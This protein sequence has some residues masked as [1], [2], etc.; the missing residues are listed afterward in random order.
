MTAHI[1]RLPGLEVYDLIFA[2]HL[3]M[4]PS[5]DQDTIHRTMAN[6]AQ[7]WVGMDDGAVVA[8]WG[9]I[10]PTF[11]SDRA[12]LW[13][14]TTD[15]LTSHVFQL[16]RHSQRAVQQMLEEYPTLI[17]HGR[18]G[19]TKSLRWLRWLGAVFEEPQGEFLPFT[20]KASQWQQRSAQS[21]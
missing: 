5:M 11:L 2:E 16:I 12:Y 20:I 3:S 15:H 19:S 14:Y 4:L 13:L 7:C 17:G 8:T 6:S 21:A 1:A 10:P 18:V 9:L